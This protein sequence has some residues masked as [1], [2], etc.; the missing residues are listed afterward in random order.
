MNE[1]LIHE[2]QLIRLFFPCAKIHSSILNIFAR[3]IRFY[4][5]E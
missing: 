4:F 2:E 5:I 3:M 1:I